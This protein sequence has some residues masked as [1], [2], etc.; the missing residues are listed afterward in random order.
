MVEHV[1]FDVHKK[2]GRRA[3]VLV[4]RSGGLEVYYDKSIHVKKMSDVDVVYNACLIAQSLGMHCGQ[5][6]VVSRGCGCGEKN[7]T[8]KGQPNLL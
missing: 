4:A 1:D 2:L 5:L 6:V 3:P 7:K 8:P